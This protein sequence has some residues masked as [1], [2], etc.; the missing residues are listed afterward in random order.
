MADEETTQR[1][2]P[3]DRR[4]RR[5]LKPPVEPPKLTV[6]IGQLLQLID[7]PILMRTLVDAPIPVAERM[8]TF[9]T[10]NRGN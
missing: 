2:T 5:A 3:R 7:T 4:P 10:G 8:I 1:T 9:L 6:P